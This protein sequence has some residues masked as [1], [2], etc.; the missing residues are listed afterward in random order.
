V[1]ILLSD[2]PSDMKQRVHKL[3]STAANAAR[4]KNVG[5][6]Q[7]KAL[8]KQRR[9]RRKTNL[10]LQQQQQ[11]RRVRETA[12]AATK[13]TKR[14]EEEQEEK[15]GKEKQETRPK[16]RA[17]LNNNEAVAAAPTPSP[18]VPKATPSKVSIAREYLQSMLLQL[19]AQRQAVDAEMQGIEA[20]LAAGARGQN[21]ID[22]EVLSEDLIT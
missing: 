16:K 15:E 20:M 12:S 19:H 3:S 11:K 1:A 2:C 5:S 6:P 8:N 14:N 10:G 18:A 13:K 4:L 7:E 22:E 17:R 9:Q 21:V